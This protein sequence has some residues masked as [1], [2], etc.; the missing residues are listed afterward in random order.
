MI[1]VQ[2]IQTAKGIEPIRELTDEERDTV[3]ATYYIGDG[4]YHYYQVGDVLPD[5]QIIP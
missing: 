4:F 3:I 5:Q 2:S 1:I